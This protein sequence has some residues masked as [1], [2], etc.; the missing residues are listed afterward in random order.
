MMDLFFTILG[1]LNIATIC[2]ACFFIGKLENRVSKIEE[3][4]SQ[5]RNT[6]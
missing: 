1:A 4:I 2:Y 5:I 6:I 3:D